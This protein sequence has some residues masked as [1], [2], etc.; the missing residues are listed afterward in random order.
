[1][2]IKL[3]HPIH[4]TA[5]RLRRFRQEAQLL[6]RLRHPG[7]AQIHESGTY[8]VGRGPTALHRH[9]VGRRPLDIRRHCEAANLNQ[10]AR[11]ELLAQVADAVQHA[12]DHGI[13]H[14]DLKPE[15]VLINEHGQPRIL[16]FGIARANGETSGVS[17]VLTADGQ[18]VGTLS[19]MAPEQLS[20]SR[21]AVTSQVDVYALG[22][23]GIP[24]AHRATAPLDRG[25]PDSQGD[26]GALPN[27]RDPR[28]QPRAEPPR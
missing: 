22:V 27:R 14:R 8:D 21:D 10:A 4:A 2:A 23:L 17:T 9:G 5:E 25:P 6:G 18:L 7:I 26:R 11:I 12:H 3:V 28:G 15:N 16:D 20:L 13:I 19:Y 1:M 24:V